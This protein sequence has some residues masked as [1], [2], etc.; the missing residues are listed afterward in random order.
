[1]S[2]GN[3]I[4]NRKIEVLIG[5]EKCAADVQDTRGETRKKRDSRVTPHIKVCDYLQGYVEL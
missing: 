1:V 4:A 2:S 5:G 3:R